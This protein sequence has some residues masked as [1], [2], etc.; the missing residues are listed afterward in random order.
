MWQNFSDCLRPDWGYL[1]IR[2]VKEYVYNRVYGVATGGLDDFIKQLT[3]IVYYYYY[4]VF[5][6]FLVSAFFRVNLNSIW[7]V[8]NKFNSLNTNLLMS[9][10]KVKG[11]KPVA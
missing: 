2:Q 4:F 1:H 7:S 5:S 8:E 3:K 9:E 6:F 11:R 10:D